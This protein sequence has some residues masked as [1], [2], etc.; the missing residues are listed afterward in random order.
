VLALALTALA[1]QVALA[2]TVPLAL[3]QQRL[4]QAGSELFRGRVGSVG[5][6]TF[7][8]E[9]RRLLR[10]TDAVVLP[11]G[12]TLAIDDSALVLGSDTRSAA[13]DAAIARLNA[14]IALVAQ[15][16]KPAI[17]PAV[18]DA[19][20]REIVA[21]SGAAAG[22]GTDILDALGR[23]IL[24]FIS[25]LRGPSVDLTQIWPVVG[26][27]GIA[28]ILFILATLG[29]ALP[30]RVRREMLVRGGPGDAQADP[31]VHLR[32]ADAALT[33]GHPREAIHALFLYVIAALAT[34]EAIRYDPALTDR[35]LL[36][37]AA[38][39]PHAESLRD[40]VGI[41]ERSWFGLREP[42]ADEA[43]RARDLALRVA[44]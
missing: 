37:R 43:R 9:A 26:M 41:Y 17:D 44:P 20:L 34:R 32:A 30:E 7:L 36:V 31:V 33:A 15:I 35:E 16:G 24:R 2:D 39:I 25:G 38:A 22:G 21:Q 10:L 3:Y 40:L 4:A 23:L 5:Q 6:S 28:V 19:R 27:L 13:V 42:S 12:G 18:A 11:S 14:H 1:P 8:D 29:R